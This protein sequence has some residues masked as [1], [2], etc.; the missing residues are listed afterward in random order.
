MT[1]NIRIFKKLLGR[2]CGKACKRKVQVTLNSFV[3]TAA[4]GVGAS[5]AANYRTAVRSFIRFNGN[6]DMALSAITADKVGQYERW[7]AVNGKCPTAHRRPLPAT[8]SSSHS[9]PWVCHR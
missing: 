6:R 7:L 5:T 3:D 4:Q 8:F 2:N 1:F 9:M